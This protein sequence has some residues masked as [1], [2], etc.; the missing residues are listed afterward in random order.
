MRDLLE[1]YFDRLWP[2]CRSISGDGL[3][4]SF[5]ILQE[6]IP[7]ELLE[8]KSGTQVLD[9][10][11][12]KEW[13]IREAYIL[14]PQGEKIADFRV[15]NLHV[16]NYSTPI[17]QKMA[18]SELQPHLHTLPEKPEAIPY[19]TTYYKERWGFCLSHNQY[20]TLPHE[21]E[22]TVVIDSTLSE[23]A[24]TLGHLVLPGSSD[25]EIF[26]SSYLCHPSMANNEL[27]G[28]L[29]LAFLY[30]QIASIPNRKYTYRFIIAPETIGVIAYLNLFG[31]HMKS[32]T[33]A[34][35]VLTCLGDRG[36]YNYKRS[37]RS[38]SIADK[39][40]EHVLRFQEEKYAIR[41]FS[42]GG[43]DERQYCSPGYNLP[44]GSLMRSVYHEFPEYHTSL[45]NKDFISFEHLEKTVSTYTKIVETFEGDLFYTGTVQHGEPMLGKHG[46]YPS[47]STPD[48]NRNEVMKLM[49][50]LTYADGQTSLLDIA[51][52]MNLPL[53]E[54]QE[55]A[56]KCLDKVLVTVE[57]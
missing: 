3:R 2:I 7:L 57:K 23:G 25:E 6:I 52:K 14:T 26:F 53:L 45:D 22:Y 56:R 1:K 40:A 8:V 15:N 35:Y 18:W 24:I 42:V 17:H 55:I 46:M 19:L 11:V 34:G 36:H 4:E 39:V 33:R 51:E 44:V 9:W 29:A 49:H 41:E 47:S 27:S 37:K 12:P 50:F 31:E 48:V 5:K 32:K 38:N 10:A 54:F 16:V 28:P 21:G 20:S 43:S 30:A 13:N